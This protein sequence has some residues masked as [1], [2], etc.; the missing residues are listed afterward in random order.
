M[1][2][3]WLRLLDAVIGV[4]DLVRSRRIRTLSRVASREEEENEDTSRGLKRWRRGTFDREAALLELERQRLDAE[5]L[6]AERAVA[7]E[8]IRQTGDREIGRL[9]LLAGVAVIG[10]VGTLWFAARVVES[11]RISSRIA[12]G[13]AWML[14]LSAIVQSFAGQV[15][16][17]RDVQRAAGPSEITPR[18]V[19]S[20]Q[21]GAL[22][23]WLF[24]AGLALASLAALIA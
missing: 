5:R 3:P 2:L 12:L 14:L 19:S 21:A 11:G 17:A 9:R 4:T 18:A 6:R 1:P 20:G 22:A 23:L 10:W 8:L 24:V 15:H 13:V 16:V 7:V